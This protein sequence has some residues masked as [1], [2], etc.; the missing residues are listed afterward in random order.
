MVPYSVNAPYWADG[1]HLDRLIALPNDKTFT[2]PGGWGYPEGMVAVQ[3]LSVDLEAGNP[4]SKAPVETR[5]LVKQ[6]EHWMGYTYLW[7]AA[8]T[9]AAL[10]DKNGADHPLTI[11][12]AS[13]PG[14]SR[15]QTCACP[16]G[17]SACSA[18]RGPPASSSASTRRR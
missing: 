5:I 10:V 14:G 9:D 4:K 17:A 15:R 2:D 11:K 6:D 13:A 12:D 18:T 8:R 1:A 7:N 3:T 16:A